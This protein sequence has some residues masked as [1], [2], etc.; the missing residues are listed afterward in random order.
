VQRKRIHQALV[1]VAK[2]KGGD[3]VVVLSSNVENRGSYN[4]APTYTVSPTY[5]PSNPY[6]VRSSPT[7]STA[8]N[9]IYTKALV[10]R[11]VD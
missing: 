8:I 10:I 5:V 4:S 9:R 11:Y 7:Y 2:E 6:S 1:K 3:G